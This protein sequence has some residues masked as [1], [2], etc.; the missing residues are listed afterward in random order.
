MASYFT[1]MMIG[2]EFNKVIKGELKDIFRDERF[3]FTVF[4]S[5]SRIWWR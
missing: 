3:E 1:K 2:N 4:F 5:S